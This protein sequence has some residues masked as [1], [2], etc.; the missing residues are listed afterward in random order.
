[1]PLQALPAPLLTAE[2][3]QA[4]PVLPSELAQPFVFG[5]KSVMALALDGEGKWWEDRTVP[6][7]SSCECVHI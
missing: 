2:Y 7:T 5:G 4:F 3:L 6:V 1:M